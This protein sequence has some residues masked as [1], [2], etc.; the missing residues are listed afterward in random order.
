MPN[1]AP[2][3]KLHGRKLL[4]MLAAGSLFAGAWSG[5]A[6]IGL[7]LKAPASEAL[8]AHGAIMV[9]GMLG[10]LI[11]LERAVALDKR[12]AYAA[13]LASGIGGLSA[14][15]GLDWRVVTWSMVAASLVF[16][17]ANVAITLRQ[18]TSFTLVL[19]LAAVL[20]A[21]GNLAWALGT[22][23]EQVVIAW[24][25]FIV[26]TIAGERLELSRLRA[27]PVFAQRLL[28]LFALALA[29][30]A[31]L[32]LFQP[33]VGG[34]IAGF[35][36]LAL[37]IWFARWDIATRTARSSGLPRYSALA[38]LSGY[39]WL[40]LAGV[41]LALDAPLFPGVIYD[42]IVH[43]IFLGFAFSMVFGHAPIILPAVLGVNVPYSPLLYLP[44]SLLH[45]SVALRVTADL[46]QWAEIRQWAGALNVVTLAL[47]A[48][49]VLVARLRAERRASSD[50][51]ASG[52]T[53]A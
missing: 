30:A 22:P 2:R 52:G 15:A 51:L 25:A 48:L 50:R 26:L 4:M 40:T 32:A 3:P 17:A 7:P 1:R 29:C 34:I 20:W 49:C 23:V 53:R 35:A 45:A 5:L 43:S 41:L 13:P 38:V 11:A 6:R 14:L 18:V 28:G 39:V 37:V 19:L 10:T 46:M 21:I 36:A 42:A 31:V 9:G 27:P 33:K 16:V 8:A 12:W 44:L 24:A 47:F